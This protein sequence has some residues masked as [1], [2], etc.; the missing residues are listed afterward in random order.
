M[1]IINYI[2]RDTTSKFILPMVMKKD[3]T[4]ED[5]S[6]TFYKTCISIFDKPE[7]DDHIILVSTYSAEPKNCRLDLSLR[8]IYDEVNN[9][10]LFI[11]EIPREYQD[12]LYSV[13]SGDYS[14]LSEQYKQKLLHFW[15]EST[16]SP[17][18]GVLY[19]VLELAMSHNAQMRNMYELQSVRGYHNK[20]TMRE[21][22]YGIG[23][24]L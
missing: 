6:K 13:I 7:F 11:F 17:L 9:K 19:D 4:Y 16:N 22:I 14:Q 10:Y 18:Y 20:P 3:A 24:E 23:V 5:I 15:K 21:L 1:D 12:D 8:K 2:G